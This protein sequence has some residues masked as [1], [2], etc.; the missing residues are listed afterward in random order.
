MAL[1]T[2]LNITFGV[3]I[4]TGTELWKGISGLCLFHLSPVMLALKSGEA[5]AKARRMPK[6]KN[7]GKNVIVLHYRGY[8]KINFIF[9]DIFLPIRIFQTQ[10]VILY[11]QFLF[12]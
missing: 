11:H 10:I 4:G 3:G 1:E 9:K 8:K 5:K 12:Q 7:K 2:F 6:E